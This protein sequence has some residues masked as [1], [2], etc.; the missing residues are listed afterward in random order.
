MVPQTDLRPLVRP[1]H[2][3]RRH[4]A[5][6]HLSERRGRVLND[7]EGAVDTLWAY[8]HGFV[9]LTMTGRIAGGKDRG[10]AL[11]LRGLPGLFDTLE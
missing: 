1:R 10:R 2:N 5:L 4:F 3:G 6:E 11:M 8:L 7:P 9:S